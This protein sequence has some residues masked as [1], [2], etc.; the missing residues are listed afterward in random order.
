MVALLSR[1]LP[2]LIVLSIVLLVQVTGALW[3]ARRTGSRTGRWVIAVLTAFSFAVVALGL[4]MRFGRV[5]RYF[6]AWWLSW[7]RAALIGWSLLSILLFFALVLSKVLPTA[8]PTDGK[9]RRLFLNAARG[10]LF[11]V[12]AA[13]LGYGTFIERTNIR[14][15]E[16]I[17]PVTGL[18]PD[19]HGMRIVQLT[20]I[21][22]GPFLTARDLD[23]AV[24]MANETRPHVALVTGD[25]I[26]GPG[27]PL[28][29]CLD[30]LA[31]LRADAGVYGC[32]G[33]HEI[34][35]GVENYTAERGARLGIR[36]LR[37]GA[38]PLKFGNGTLNFAGVDYQRMHEP[39]LAGAERMLLPG[40]FNILLSHNPDVFPVSAAMGYDLTISGHTHGGQVRVE[41][42]RKDLNIARFY[43]PFVDGL[44]RNGPASIFVSRGIGTIVLP[45]RLG[46]AP[47]V[48]LL[49]LVPSTEGAKSRL[50]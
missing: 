13:V 16:Q 12:P 11:T 27:D 37:S 32:M 42:L 44:Y 4:A 45:A 38:A 50:G 3:L 43:T 2:D 31:R 28:D 36:F 48:A 5:A 18:H 23:R 8:R 6:P 40:A 17:I 41:I 1:N 15:R 34:Y 46:A 14:V 26:T 20:D 47:E 9:S 30:G 10:A 24:N 49:R 21:H 22:M 19:L 25:L 35:A 29:T 39:Y 33:N 7:G